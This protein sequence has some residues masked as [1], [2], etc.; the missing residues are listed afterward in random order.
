MPPVRDAHVIPKSSLGEHTMC[1]PQVEPSGDGVHEANQLRPGECTI[2][3]VDIYI[4]ICVCVCDPVVS[5]SFE[6]QD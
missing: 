1:F 5:P 6:D 2:K 3:Q 4:Y